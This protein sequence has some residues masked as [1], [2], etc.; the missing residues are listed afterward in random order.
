MDDPRAELDGLTAGFESGRVPLLEF[1]RS[2]RSVLDSNDIP[3]RKE[4]GAAVVGCFGRHTEGRDLMA[5]LL[6]IQGFRIILSE[7]GSDLT[8]M[9]DQCSDPDVTVLC[10]SAQSTYDCP[11]LFE[12]GDLLREAG[13]RE[14]IIVNV[15]GAAVTPSAAERMDCDVY[16]STALESAKA[17]T[18]KVLERV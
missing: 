3:P 15:G 18:R 4:L 5:C 16:C 8:G 11:E 17:I 12:L 13:M 1:I 2:A 14:R 10:I 6:E 7:R 9:I